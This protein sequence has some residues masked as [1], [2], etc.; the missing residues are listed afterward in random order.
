V[1]VRV[2]Q[3]LRFWVAEVTRLLERG[4]ASGYFRREL[5]PRP[6]AE[7]ILSLFEGSLLFSKASRKPAAIESARDLAIS[8]LQ[9]FRRVHRRKTR[10]RRSSAPVLAYRS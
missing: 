7:A 9:A 1:R 3:L 6:A 4:R 8:Y 10:N 5:N 2:A